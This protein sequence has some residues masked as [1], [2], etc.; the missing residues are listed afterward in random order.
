MKNRLEYEIHVQDAISGCSLPPL[1]I[2]ALVENAIKHGINESLTGGKIKIDCR[3]EKESIVITITNDGQLK[4]TNSK[5]IGITNLKK[6][7]AILY[8]DN[9]NFAIFEK[10]GKVIA[11]FKLPKGVGRK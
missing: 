1:S 4:T 11:E 2:Q 3:E 6:R 9:F 7:F 10:N 8:P 5:G